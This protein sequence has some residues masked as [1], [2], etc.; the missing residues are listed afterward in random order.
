MIVDPVRVKELI[1][2]YYKGLYKES[3]HQKIRLSA[4]SITHDRSKLIVRTSTTKR[5]NAKGGVGL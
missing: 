3:N 2:S 1:I 4:A 5:G